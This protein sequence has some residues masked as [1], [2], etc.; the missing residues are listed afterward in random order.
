MIIYPAVDIRAGRV[1]RLREGD[2]ERQVVYSEDPVSIAAHWRALGA[3]WLH[4]VN[5]DGAFQTAND[6]LS[7][8]AQMA[9]LGVSIQFG[10]GVRSLEDA[11]R[12]LDLGVSR[13]VFGT[14][15]VT[16]PE[17]VRTAIESLGAERVC[18][19]LDARDGKV[20]A[21]GWAALTDHTP[22]V[23]G[24]LF[25]DMGVIHA[26]YTDIS[27]DGGLQGVNVDATVEL[28]VV[29]GLQV[30]ASGGVSSL[31]DLH[32]LRQS[33][34]VAGAV[35]GMALY[36]GKIALPDALMIASGEVA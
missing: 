2:P 32:R 7:A 17:F 9:G 18:V 26:L 19:A 30:I 21:H 20:A 12:A 16:Q 13:V 6:T 22:I 33:G 1:V 14:A 28:A 10:G 5:L 25:R 31:A 34:K 23:L 4:V 3:S 29:S 27:R 8:V 35:I 24:K 11:Q 36:E 15:A